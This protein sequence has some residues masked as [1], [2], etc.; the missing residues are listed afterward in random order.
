MK[1]E[2]EVFYKL[3]S[4]IASSPRFIVLPGE[5][6]LKAPEIV[7]VGGPTQQ[8]CNPPLAATP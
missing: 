1:S 5:V 6:G 4:Q 3:K 7:G 8:K 2:Q